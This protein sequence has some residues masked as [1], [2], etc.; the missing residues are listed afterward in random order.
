V[1]AHHSA[2]RAVRADIATLEVDAIVVYER[3]L[4][5]RRN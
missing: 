5:G 2:L 1:T 4:D 3:L